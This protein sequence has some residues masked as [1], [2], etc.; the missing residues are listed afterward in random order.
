MAYQM[1]ATDGNGMH[2]S[3]G[4]YSIVHFWKIYISKWE[5]KWFCS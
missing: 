1:A 5:N 4:C 3:V 2:G